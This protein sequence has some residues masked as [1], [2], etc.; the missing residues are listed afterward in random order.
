M[1][2]LNCTDLELSIYLQGLEEGYLPTCS[3]DTSRSEQLRSNPIARKSYQH[4]NETVTFPGSQSLMTCAHS[5]EGGGGDSSTL[6]PAGSPS[7]ARTS[8]AQEKEKESMVTDPG[9]GGRWRELSVRYDRDSCSWKTSQLLLFEGL[10]EYLET[11]PPWG[12][13]LDGACWELETPAVRAGG[14]ES[15]SWPRPT[16]SMAKRGWGQTNARQENR[17][18]ER[19]KANVF[20][21]Q[22]LWGWRPRIELLEWIIGWPIGWSGLDA[23]ETD[24]TLG[25]LR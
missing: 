15:G 7:P 25:W 10:T 13:M 6:S 24:K 11:W 16:A 5:T 18:S 1:E 22:A 17:Y 3:S 21:E 19:V 23:L 14:I 4:D 8:P 9:Y 2:A 20:H 12:L